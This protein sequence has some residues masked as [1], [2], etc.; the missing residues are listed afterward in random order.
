MKH[1]QKHNQKKRMKEKHFQ[2]FH[3]LRSQL[4]GQGWETQPTMMLVRR[5][6][7][8]VLEAFTQAW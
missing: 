3:A 2:P 8:P 6:G 4:S 5:G 7:V 1:H